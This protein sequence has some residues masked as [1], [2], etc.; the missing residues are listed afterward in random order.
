MEIEK[1]FLSIQDKTKIDYIDLYQAMK[2]SK[3]KPLGLNWFSVEGSLSFSTVLFCPK[4]PQNESKFYFYGDNKLISEQYQTVLPEE[5]N[6]IEGIINVEDY[7]WDKPELRHK[8]EKI[9][10]KYVKKK[11]IELFEKLKDD[12]EFHQMYSWNLKKLL[13]VEEIYSSKIVNI[14]K[15]RTTKNRF[16]RF[17][18]IKDNVIYYTFDEDKVMKM[19]NVDFIEVLIFDS[20]DEDLIQKY[21]S[22]TEK[23]FE[24]I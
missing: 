2:G 23:K 12:D 6:F 20:F 22:S 15:F 9:I 18:D 4:A 10:K 16:L 1:L 24:K 3:E 19:S 14:L 21:E 5:L 7:I 17:Q 13:L 11:S 8:F